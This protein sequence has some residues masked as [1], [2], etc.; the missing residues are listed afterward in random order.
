M[1]ENPKTIYPDTLAVK[2]L[3]R[4]EQYNI[5]VLPVI[6]EEGRPIGMIHLHDI[7]KAGITTMRVNNKDS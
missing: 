7:L 4:M 5:T 2:A 6:D 1:I 3:D